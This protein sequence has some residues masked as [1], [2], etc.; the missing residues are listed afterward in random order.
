MK[1]VP[2]I[3]FALFA[4]FAAL[5]VAFA[6]PV[7]KVGTTGDYRPLTWYDTKTQSYEGSAIDLVEAFARDRGYEIRFVGTTWPTLMQGLTGGEYQMAAGGISKT[8]ARLKVAL[9]SAPVEHSGKVP[10]VRCG[11]EQRFATL[12]DIDKAG[13]TVVENRGGTNEKFALANIRNA[14]LIIVPDNH[15]P[16]DYLRAGRADVMFTDSIEAL[17]LQGKDSGLCAV[18]ADHPYDPVDKVFLFRQDEGALRDEF[19]AWLKGRKG[20]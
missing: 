13:V 20:N 2:R 18:N 16:F 1:S 17:Y 7:L 9:A 11:D 5:G 15:Q 10:L 19:N 8:D 3:A 12:A 14:T 6:D 4:T